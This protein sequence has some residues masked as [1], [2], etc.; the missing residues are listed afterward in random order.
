MRPLE[1][2]LAAEPQLPGLGKP[3]VFRLRQLGVLAL[4]SRGGASDG[5]SIREYGRPRERRGKPTPSSCSAP[6]PAPLWLSCPIGRIRLPK[7][8]PAPA[9]QS[10][11]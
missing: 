10:K 4:S 8:F 7:G 5:Y 6:L 2:L 9:A 11:T 1:V 3:P